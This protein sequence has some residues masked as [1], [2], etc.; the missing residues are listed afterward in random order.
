M[1]GSKTILCIEDDHFISEMYMRA[2]RNA[3]YD[4][5][6]IDT[7][8][9]AVETARKGGYDLIL[10]DLWIPEKNGI[11]VLKELRGED[12]KGLPETKII[13]TTNYAQDDQSRAAL[14]AQAD[15]YFIK[16]EMTPKKIVEIT[17]QLIGPAAG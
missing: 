1:A 8:A 14:A 10:L 9:G 13:I 4:V 7:G 17:K 12:G 11:E 2:L 5:T 6:E 15:G 16:A 3:G